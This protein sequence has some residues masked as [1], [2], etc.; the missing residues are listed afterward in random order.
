[1]RW[2]TAKLVYNF[3][4]G[5][6]LT[7]CH[8]TTHFWVTCNKEK[9][10]KSLCRSTTCYLKLYIST[11]IRAI[12]LDVLITDAPPIDP[13]TPVQVTT[14][15][16]AL[17][18]FTTGS[19][20]LPKIMYRTHNFLLHQSR[21]VSH[22]YM[23]IHGINP[24]G[25]VMG[26]PQE[27][28]ETG[29]TNMPILFLHQL[30]LGATSM[31]HSKIKSYEPASV[32]ALMEDT[33]ITNSVL[34]PAIAYQLCLYCTEHNRRLPTKV[35]AVGG[36]P[37]YRHMADVMLKAMMDQRVIIV[38]GSTEAEPISF[39]DANTKVAKESESDF[40]GHFVG[41]SFIEGGVRIVQIDADALRK[42]ED[43]QLSQGEVGEIIVSGWNVNTEDAPES[44]ILKDQYGK[45]WLKLGDAGFLDKD[46]N[47]WLVGRV[48]WLVER[49]GKRHW[50]IITEE[51]VLQFLRD[52][53]TLA[54]YLYR[55]SQA[56]LII[57]APNGLNTRQEKRLRLYLQTE[58]I[59]VDC[60]K[61][62]KTMPRDRRHNSKPDMAQLF[63]DKK[64]LVV[65]VLVIV[66]G[67]VAFAWLLKQCN[68]Q[69]ALY[70]ALASLLVVSWM[71]CSL[72][73]V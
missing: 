42:V 45:L 63:S 19:T 2:Y 7:G 36:A 31:L 55:N 41:T 48:S 71:L 8:R 72:C 67:T 37:I 58:D 64:P 11:A 35:I 43:V 40:M 13:K 29:F 34:S 47:L 16:R 27:G 21:A 17:A 3:I 53:A 60:M 22:T 28:T 30:K 50:S 52:D 9:I 25:F 1:M 68:L 65:K 49:N 44:R 57:E 14:S 18:T 10:E 73:I 46:G 39:T 15:E 70:L 66:I 23:K 69:L 56:H 20:G 33:G 5:R 24:A 61:I 6:C 26:S 38:Y 32:V 62:Y 51:K 54:A 12:P 4:H 59:P